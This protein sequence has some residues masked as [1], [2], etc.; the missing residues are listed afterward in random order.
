MPHRPVVAA[1]FFIV[2]GLI[3]RAG[4][5]TVLALSS[6]VYVDRLLCF[7]FLHASLNHARAIV[8]T[9]VACVHVLSGRGGHHHD[10]SLLDGQMTLLAAFERVEPSQA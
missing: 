6:L 8:A 5:H 4:L 7:L 1:I 3:E 10:L 2:N 9:R